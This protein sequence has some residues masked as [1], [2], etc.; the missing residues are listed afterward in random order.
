A[1]DIGN[2]IVTNMVMLG[3]VSK[4]ADLPVSEK[5]LKD[6]LKESISSKFLKI[7]LEA[8]ERGVKAVQ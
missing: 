8:F 5:E 7:D 6:A 3:A 4:F 1:A 2:V